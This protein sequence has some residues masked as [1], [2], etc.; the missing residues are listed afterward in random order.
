M[1][2]GHWLTGDPFLLGRN[3][4]RLLPLIGLDLLVLGVLGRPPIVLRRPPFHKIF[5][6]H[7]RELIIRVARC[8]LVV[9][10]LREPMVLGCRQIVE[11]IEIST[12]LG[13]RLVTKL[14]V[15]R[16][17]MRVLLVPKLHRT[18]LFLFPSLHRL[19]VPFIMLTPP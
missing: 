2:N 10:I 13:L 5:R 7:V 17:R 16:V 3:E 12:A 15:V 8:Q 4:H 9:H 6:H 1:R 11:G 18:I 19:G 14:L